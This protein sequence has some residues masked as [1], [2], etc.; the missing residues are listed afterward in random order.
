MPSN[1]VVIMGGRVIDPARNIDGPADVLIA[2]GKVED[3]TERPL[4]SAPSGYEVIDATGLVVAPGFIDL[5]THL[6]E[7]GL[8]H[9]ETIA[10]GASAAAR[11]GFT[12]VCAMPNTEPAQDSA[13]VIEDVLRRAASGAAVRVLPIGAITVGR[14][15]KTLAPLAELAE[16]G[17]VGFSDDGDPVADANIMRQALSYAG[18]L[19]LPI[20]NHAEDKSLVR[21][22]VMNEGPVANR[23]GLAGVPAEAEAVMVARDI[24][25]AEVTGGR[26]HIPH[27]STRRSVEHVR[28]AKARGLNVTAEVT[29]HHLT[30]TDAWV[31]G[32]HGE[33]PD[34]VGLIAY[35]TNTKVNPPLRSADDVEAVIEALAD[36]TIDFIA[37]DHAPHAETDKVCTYAEAAHGINLLETAFG[38]VMSLVADG[39]IDLVTLIHRLTAAPAA[40]LGRQMGTLTQGYPADLVLLDPTAGWEVDTRQFASRSRNTPL[41]GVVLRGRVISTIYGGKVVHDIRTETAATAAGRGKA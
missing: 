16:A 2:T 24:H 19:G 33:T 25:L 13:S 18:D 7:P 8:E 22:G 21:G 5:H 29:P 17:A 9:K 27:V 35:D 40:F 30:L 4:E 6:R 39:R 34:S 1:K 15:G 26:L 11:G 36:G 20:I 32:L 14:R 37:T 10:T 38:S 41:G 3:V 28:A 31:Y 23:L 12:T